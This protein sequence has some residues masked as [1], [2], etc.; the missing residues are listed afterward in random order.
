M[1][2]LHP[3]KKET[4]NKAII[5]AVD[6]IKFRFASFS[7]VSRDSLQFDLLPKAFAIKNTLKR[8]SCPP[9]KWLMCNKTM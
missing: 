8:K 7:V 3:L 5:K 6:K 1:H 4:I 2:V 9:L